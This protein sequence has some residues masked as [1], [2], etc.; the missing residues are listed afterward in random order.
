MR[1]LFLAALLFLCSVGAQA[2]EDVLKRVETYLNRLSTITADFTQASPD[3]SLTEGKFYFER[4]GKMRWDYAPPTPILIVSSGSQLIY[5]DKEL[6]QTTYIPMDSTPAGF[7]MN[8]PIRFDEGVVVEEA[9]DVGG[10]LRVTLHQAKNPEEGKL[11]LEFSDSPLI[12][13]NLIVTDATNQVTS[14]S[15]KNAHFGQKLD[16]ALFSLRK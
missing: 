4:P 11:T 7:L 10:V 2:K 12:L 1:A 3:G 14:V 6:A 13:R 9:S 8:D 15:L 5:F 16:S